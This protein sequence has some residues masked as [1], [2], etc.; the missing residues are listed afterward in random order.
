MMKLQDDS[1]T[2]ISTQLEQIVSR[3]PVH[4]GHQLIELGCGRAETIVKL[5][6]CFP[7][8]ECIATEVDQI[9]HAE[10]L[11]S[12]GLPNLRFQFGG[13][14]KIDLPDA[15]ANYVIMLKSLHHVPMALMKQSL[16]EVRRV[17]IPGG[18]AYLA[19]PVYA[20][21]FNEILKRFNDEQVV[22]QAAF[23]TVKEAVESGAFE[24]V[25]QVFFS[26]AR[27]F[28]DFAE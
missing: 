2:T 27:R 26:V 21:P 18:L 8:L 23:E 16:N 1:Q 10:N 13:A 6:K 9:Q 3:L 22:R 4:P 17:L 20:G 19:E 25:D 12:D 5:A 28:A 11:A 14:E 15:S 24:L 7:G